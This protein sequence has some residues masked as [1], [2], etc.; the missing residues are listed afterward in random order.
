MVPHANAIEHTVTRGTS[1][2]D[3][4]AITGNIPKI[5]KEGHDKARQV[6]VTHLL[7][8]IGLEGGTAIVGVPIEE[9]FIGSCKNG[10]IEDLQE[11]SVVAI[12]HKV[13]DGVHAM[14]VPGSGLAK[15]QGEQEGL[16]KILMTAGFDWRELGCSI[17]LAES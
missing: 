11:V 2:Q 9:V 10:C 6:V 5:D 8:Y 13:A 3:T 12:G 1:P 15:L 14:V 7:D 4:V 16:N 17:R